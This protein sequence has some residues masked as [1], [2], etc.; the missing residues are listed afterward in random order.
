MML[1]WVVSGEKFDCVAEHVQLYNVLLSHYANFDII[2]TY[3]SIYGVTYQYSSR[4][5]LKVRL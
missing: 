4:S 1:L 3:K 5:N 2:L